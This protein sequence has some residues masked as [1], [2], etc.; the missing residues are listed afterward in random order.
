[1]EDISAYGGHHQFSTREKEPSPMIWACDK[2]THLPCPREGFELHVRK[3]SDGTGL[4]AMALKYSGWKL[5]NGIVKK[6]TSLLKYDAQKIHLTKVFL[7][8]KR[9]TRTLDLLWM[10][11]EVKSWH[12]FY[13]WQSLTPVFSLMLRDVN[14]YFG[15]NNTR[16]RIKNYR[17]LLTLEIFICLITSI[18]LRI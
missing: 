11:Q 6:N 12:C 4:G 15:T 1:M 3:G 9:E 14:D 17:I 5:S 13:L 8:K 10:V 16:Y 2:W 7:L 18:L